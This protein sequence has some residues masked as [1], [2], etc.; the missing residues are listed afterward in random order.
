[1]FF[2]NWIEETPHPLD[3]DDIVTVRH[4]MAI[5][6]LMMAPGIN[7]IALVWWAS[8]SKGDKY[9]ASMVNWARAM[10]IVGIIFISV[11][12]AGILFYMWVMG[13]MEINN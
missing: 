9:P 8:H 3:N 1:M 2:K 12:A 5:F 13:K 11:T 6:V 7:I 4:W 10:I